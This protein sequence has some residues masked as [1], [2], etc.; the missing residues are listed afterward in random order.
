L[1]GGLGEHLNLGESFL[2]GALRGAKEEVNKNIVEKS[3]EKVTRFKNTY[4]RAK[5][6]KNREFVDIFIFR[7][8]GPFRVDKKEAT[9]NGFYKTEKIFSLAPKKLVTP[10]FIYDLK[11]Y[12]AYRKYQANLFKKFQKSKDTLWILWEN[13]IRYVSHKK[14]I[15]PLVGLLSKKPNLIKYKIAFD[16]IV[17]RAAALLLVYAG[18]GEV[19]ALTGSR[20]AAR[21]FKKYKVYYQFKKTV[22]SILNEKKC[23]LCPYEKLSKGKTPAG[24]YKLVKNK[25]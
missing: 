18:V 11:Y 15:K 16:K 21:V 24:F 4:D 2:N 19:H 3:L 17:G 13:K 1:W 23:D 20:E 8:S 5:G 25:F 10:A 12:L 6:L 9:K 14:G 7:N 22:P